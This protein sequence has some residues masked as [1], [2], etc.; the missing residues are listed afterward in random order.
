VNTGTF[1]R[2]EVAVTTDL[3]TLLLWSPRILGVGVCLFLG[4]FALDAFSQ[5]KPFIQALPDFIVHLWPAALVLAVVAVSWRLPWLG[6]VLFIA[7]ALAYASI[8][9][10]RLD[11]IA[12]ISGPLALVGVLFLVS[13][14]YRRRLGAV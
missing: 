5:S 13:W 6:G 4:L 7:C 14:V 8:A 11:W 9:Y 3:E 12:V 10:K 2:V 1:I